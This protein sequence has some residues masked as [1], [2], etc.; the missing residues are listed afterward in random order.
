M[1]EPPETRAISNRAIEPGQH[2]TLLKSTGGLLPRQRF[3]RHQTALRTIVKRVLRVKTLANE[4]EAMVQ[5]ATHVQIRTSGVA[6]GHQCRE[7]S[8]GIQDYLQRCCRVPR[9]PTRMATCER[10]WVGKGSSVPVLEHPHWCCS[11]IERRRVPH[12]RR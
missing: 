4:T 11:A 8:H 1:P 12:Q 2:V 3:D 6:E 10:R 7:R 5:R 9:Q